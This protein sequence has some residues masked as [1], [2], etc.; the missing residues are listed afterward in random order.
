MMRWLAV[1]PALVTLIH[2]QPPAPPAAIHTFEL[3][4]IEVDGGNAT[5]TFA[6]SKRPA[7]ARTVTLV[8]VE[9]QSP[10]MEMPVGKIENGHGGCLGPAQPWWNGTVSLTAAPPSSQAVVVIYPPARFAKS[11]PKS[12]LAA[13]ALPSGVLLQNVSAA[14][15]LTGNG[16]PDL[17]I[18]VYCCLNPKT[19]A[20][21]CDL[22][23]TNYFQKRS[24]R[25]VLIRHVAPC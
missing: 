15:D 16:T 9:G 10:M 21:D 5:V 20:S 6:F 17:L 3:S 4:R 1:V 11:I 22:T 12:D 7:T 8:P 25:W 14:I 23:C 2:A 18:V 19:L 24:G 13:S